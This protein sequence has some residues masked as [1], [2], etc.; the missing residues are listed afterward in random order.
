MPHPAPLTDRAGQYDGLALSGDG[1]RL[2]FT[3]WVDG[4]VGSRDFQNRSVQLL[5]LADVELSGSVRGS[6]CVTAYSISPDLPASRI[7]IVR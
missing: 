1:Q 2:Y 7:V 5:D 4:E 3:S 6:R